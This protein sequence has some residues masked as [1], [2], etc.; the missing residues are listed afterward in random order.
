MEG[1]LKEILPELLVGDTGLAIQTYVLNDNADALRRADSANSVTIEKR[2]GGLLERNWGD[3]E[4]PNG[5]ARGVSRGYRY[6]GWL[7]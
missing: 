4:R 2:I 3:W 6:F 1:V 5:W 7:N